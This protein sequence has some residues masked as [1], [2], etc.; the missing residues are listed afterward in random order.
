MLQELLNK[1]EIYRRNYDENM[2]DLKEEVCSLKGVIEERDE[3]IAKKRVMIND[4]KITS[5]K[6]MLKVI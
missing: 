2:Q 1:K 4:K 3:T 5:W 6:R